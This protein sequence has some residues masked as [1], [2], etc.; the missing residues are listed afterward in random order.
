LADYA[1]AA[2]LARIGVV[3]AHA[4]YA[5]TAEVAP[6]SADPGSPARRAPYH[7]EDISNICEGRSIHIEQLEV[8]ERAENRRKRGL[9]AVDTWNEGVRGTQHQ[10]AVCPGLSRSRR[11]L[12]ERA[13]RQRRDGR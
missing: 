9:S 5:T 10:V 13:R 6:D 4:E 11:E 3:A 8:R 12:G 7:P 1:R 2:S